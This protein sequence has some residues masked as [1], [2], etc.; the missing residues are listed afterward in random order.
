MMGDYLGGKGEVALMYHD[1]DYYVTNQRDKAVEAVLRR[2]YPNIKI[3]AKQGVADPS[4]GEAITSAILTQHPSVNAIYSPWD[5][6]AEGSV[7]AVR[8]SG[9]KNVGVFTIDL[10]ANNAMDMVTAGNVKG[11][12]ADLPY[13]LGETMAKIGALAKLGKSTPAFTTVPAIKVNKDNIKTE[14][15][16]SLNR[17]LPA[18]IQAVLK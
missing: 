1:A 2:D 11:I 13:V 12:V 7:A 6:V 17:P 5:T 3:V 8:T 14:W 10:G 9:K 16:R 15:Q 4:N 18:E